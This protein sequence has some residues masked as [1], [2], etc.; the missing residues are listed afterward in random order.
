MQGESLK[1]AARAQLKAAR[2]QYDLAMAKTHDDAEDAW[3]RLLAQISK[4]YEKLRAGARGN[5]KDEQWFYGKVTRERSEDELLTYLHHAR[6]VDTHG[7]AEVTIRD[8]PGTQLLFIGPDGHQRSGWIQSLSVGPD[9]VRGEWSS[10]DPT[11]KLAIQQ[12]APLILQDVVDRGVLYK[13][14][15]RHLGQ[16]LTHGTAIEIAQLATAYVED[17]L[18]TAPPA[19]P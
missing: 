6:N 14:P 19:G 3:E 11:A 7:L 16:P 17:L 2:A 5:K 15:T 4:F 8:V 9:G 18:R 10:A 12:T 13:V 1:A